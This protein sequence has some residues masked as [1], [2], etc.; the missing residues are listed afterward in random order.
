MKNHSK[1][2]FLLG[3]GFTKSAFPRAPLN[4]DLLEAISKDNGKTLSK[5]KNED[6]TNDIEKLLTSLDLKATE[7]DE[8][9]KDRST[10]NAEIASYFRKFRFSKFGADIPL[11]LK[12][13]A[14]N[15]LNQNDAIVCL[16]YDCFL[17]GALDSL[18]VWSPKGGYARINNFLSNS[19]PKNPKN[20]EI[21]KIHGS[22]NF[23]ESPVIGENPKQTAIGALINS[24][25][26]PKTSTHSCYRYGTINSKLYIIAPSFVKIPHRDIAAM[27]LDLMKVAEVATDFVII[28]CGMRP[29]DNFLWLLLTCFLNRIS[30]PKHRLVILDPSSEK[31]R[32]R[33]SNYWIGDIRQFD[34]IVTIPCKLEDGISRLE[35]V[36][37]G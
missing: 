6:K 17:E 8:I 28:G 21:Y 4:K 24:A 25:I 31:I 18:G 2:I 9:K 7:R 14:L 26:Y 19:F 33:I 27:M 35:S 5:Y 37:K 30:N 13:F 15:V 11:W 23:I 36:L 10:I 34:N 12:T 22:E 1:R 20:I 16:N 32:E 29:E 3:A